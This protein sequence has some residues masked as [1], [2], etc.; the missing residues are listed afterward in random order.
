MISLQKITR[1]L[2]G[3]KTFYINAFKLGNCIGYNPFSAAH[4]RLSSHNSFNISD[5]TYFS[6]RWFSTHEV[7]R[8]R[9]VEEH[10]SGSHL[11]ISEKDYNALADATLQDISDLLDALDDL[12]NDDFDISSSQGVMNIKLGAAGT[13]VINKQ[14]PNRQLWWS[15]PISG[16]RRYELSAAHTDTITQNMLSADDLVLRPSQWKFSRNGVNGNESSSLLTD[17]RT[18]LLKAV[19]VDILAD[20]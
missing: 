11:L 13:W 12:N 18:E 17:L 15:S 8:V 9:S 19:N 6:A 7:K 3:I 20:K 4:S 2:R 10:A 14:T 16:P 5:A 1:T